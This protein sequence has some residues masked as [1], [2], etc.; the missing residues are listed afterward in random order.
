M[1]ISLP[2]LLS[3]WSCTPILSWYQSKI[4]RSL[5]YQ[6]FPQHS[7]CSSSNS[8]FDYSDFFLWL[9]VFMHF[10]GSY[11]SWRTLIAC[12]NWI[13]V[14]SLSLHYF[15][16]GSDL[17]LI[18]Y[19]IVQTQ[20]WF[21]F[22]LLFRYS[23]LISWNTSIMSNN[24]NTNTSLDPIVNP[25]SVYFYMLPIVDRNSLVMFLMEVD[26][27]IGNVLWWLLCLAR[28]NYVLLM[29]PWTNQD[30]THLMLRHGIKWTIL[31]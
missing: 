6:K 14:Y 23:F 2:L 12:F 26:I 25:A 22:F 24:Q 18:C 31:S 21:D 20:F 17:Q 29:V 3:L 5:I 19:Q 11:I 7:V 30:R 15:A 10:F 28:T 9:C 16:F 1:K 13:C 8:W 27:V 4:Q